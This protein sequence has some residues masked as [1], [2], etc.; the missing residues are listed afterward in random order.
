MQTLSV[1]LGDRSYPIYI[2]EGLLRQP[3]L[4]L[5]HIAGGQVLVVTNDTVA[6]ALSRQSQREFIGLRLFRTDFA[7]W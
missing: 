4:L 7:G 3:K 5:N 2:G 1:D 6:P